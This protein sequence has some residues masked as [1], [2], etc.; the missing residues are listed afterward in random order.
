MQTLLATIRVQRQKYAA[1][2]AENKSAPDKSGALVICWKAELGGLGVDH[3]RLGLFRAVADRDLARLLGLGDLAHEIDVQQA[4]LEGRVLHLHMIG[5]LEDALEG[6]RGDALIEHLAI[7]LFLGLL[8]AL[9]RQRVFFRFDRQ[10]V[11]AETGD[12]DR[13]A[14]VVLARAFDVVGRIAR[15]RLKT[16]SIENSRSK[17]TVER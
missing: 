16:S 11:F 13:D 10:I 1:P 15:G 6:A 2:H 12:R 3:L 7:L 5:K 17:P 4:V 14:I 8:G 9:D